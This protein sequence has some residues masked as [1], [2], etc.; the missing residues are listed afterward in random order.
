M[1]TPFATPRARALG[2]GLRTCREARD[3][4]VRQLARLIGVHAQELS[5]WEY[6]K[7]VPKVEQ[8]ALLMGALVVEPEERKR[9]LEL[10]YSAAEVSWL[11]KVMPGVSLNPGTYVQY[12][13]EASELFGWEPALVPGLLQ[14][15]AYA[16]V[17]LAGIG[18]V[19]EHR[20]RLAM[21]RE[22]RRNLLTGP[23]PTPF[24][25]VV[26]DA[27]LQPGFIEPA[28]MVEQL[29]F[30]LALSRRSNVSLQVLRGNPKFHPGLCG[31]FVILDFPQL[32]PIVFV[33]QY[34]SSAY[35]YAADQVADYRSAAK[36]LAALAL[37]EQESCAFIAEVIAELGGSDG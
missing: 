28:V 30:L 36:T 20:E 24:R 35:L 26:A 22:S 34:R 2:F 9:L 8:V 21:A 13:R 4:G 19:G 17:V 10:A 25:A 6:G 7:R 12:E 18:V 29:R 27:V 16:R 14:T 37:S 5:N 1:A 33:E 23:W 3:F 11:E 15:P 31:P 32:P